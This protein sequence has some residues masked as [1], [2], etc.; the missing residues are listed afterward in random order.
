MVD[1]GC[2]SSLIKSEIVRNF[3]AKK[4]NE[5]ENRAK[6]KIEEEIKAR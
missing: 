4:K 1:Y 5:E 6:R 2:E 3:A